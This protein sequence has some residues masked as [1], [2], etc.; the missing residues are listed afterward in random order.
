VPF[1][2]RKKVEKKAYEKSK[3]QNGIEG[4]VAIGG[5]GNIYRRRRFF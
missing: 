1:R 3:R 4:L 2:T 5:D